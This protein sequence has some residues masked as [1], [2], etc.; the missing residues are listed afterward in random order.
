MN[1]LFQSLN[2]NSIENL[3][4]QVLQ[5]QQNFQGNPREKIAQML[6]NGQIT[7]EQLNQAQSRATQIMQLFNR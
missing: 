2:G 6:Q 3:K 7:Q 5:F 1:D 4:R